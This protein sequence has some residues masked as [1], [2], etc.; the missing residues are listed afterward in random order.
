MKILYICTHNRC[1]SI[2]SEAITNAKGGGQLQAFSAGS[3]PSGE[4]HPLS[5]RYLQEMGYNTA[6]LKSQSWDDFETIAP[7]IVITVC[8]SAASEACPVWFGDT[9]KMHWGLADPSKLQGS[10]SD[11]RDAFVDAINTIERRVDQLLAV[12]WKNLDKEQ[13]QAA[14]AQLAET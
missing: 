5:L 13:R 6:G 8:D 4:V 11:I 10:E 2:L 7:D 1:R 14:L 3:Q 12:N 9:L